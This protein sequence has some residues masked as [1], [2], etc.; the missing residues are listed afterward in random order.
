MIRRAGDIE[1]A[2]LESLSF[3]FIFL[4]ARLIHRLLSIGGRVVT[5]LRGSRIVV[6]EWRIVI[7]AILLDCLYGIAVPMSHDLASD[8]KNKTRILYE[9]SSR[10]PSWLD[11]KSKQP[12][13]ATFHH[14]SR[15][16]LCGS[17]NEVEGRAHGEHYDRNPADMLNHP[18]FLPR[19]AESDEENPG[20]GLGVYM[21]DDSLI[22]LAGQISERRGHGEG[23]IERGMITLNRREQRT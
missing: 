7:R 2:A 10:K 11:S 18:L 14:P 13:E 17:R 16:L 8:E 12:F 23:N 20:A 19:A 22:L 9:V 4:A 5:K 1:I 3:R 15:S 21:A 6:N